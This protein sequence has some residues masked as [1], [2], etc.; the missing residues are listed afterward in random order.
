M[1]SGTSFD[2]EGMLF[3]NES[4]SQ[5]E[6]VKEQVIDSSSAVLLSC[7]GVYFF[8]ILPV[9]D[10]Y[11][12]LLHY[13]TRLHQ[14]NLPSGVWRPTWSFNSDGNFFALKCEKL[15]KGNLKGRTCSACVQLHF[16]PYLKTIMNSSIDSSLTVVASRQKDIYS[17][18][19]DWINKRNTAVHSF[20][21][22]R[23]VGVNS[24]RHIACLS[25]KINSYSRYVSTLNKNYILKKCMC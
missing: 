16:S 8:D 14:Q 23:L 1:V 20:K 18:T 13:P 24:N 7:M 6:I 2:A 12:F 21:K 17:S 15:V 10:H 9:P 5:A 25:S 4:P 11:D 3:A 22:A 19:H